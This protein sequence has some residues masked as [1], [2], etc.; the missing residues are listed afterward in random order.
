M[1]VGITYWRIN[2]EKKKADVA[3]SLQTPIMR[4]VL[5]KLNKIKEDEGHTN[6][7]ETIGWIIEKT[8]RLDVVES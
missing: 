1:L 2:M 7:G 6:A 8:E 3:V 5:N 4:S